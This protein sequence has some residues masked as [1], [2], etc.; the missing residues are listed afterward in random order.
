NADGVPVR[1]PAGLP[2]GVTVTGF[3]SDDREC[4]L[5]ANC[6][7]YIWSLVSWLHYDVSECDHAEIQNAG[8]NSIY[9]NANTIVFK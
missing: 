6:P 3:K 7:D 4:S 2:E 9:L 5:N 8:Q 1:S